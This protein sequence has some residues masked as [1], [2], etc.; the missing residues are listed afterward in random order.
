MKKQKTGHA[1]DDLRAMVTTLVM[2]IVAKRREQ[3]AQ[4]CAL[5]TQI[6]ALRAEV[7]RLKAELEAAQIAVATPLD[8]RAQVAARMSPERTQHA[9][10]K[11]REES[12]RRIAATYAM[13]TVGD[14]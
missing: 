9:Y 1:D 4:M 12:N 10:Q 3:S 7:H 14:S 13:L 2:A 5:N 6:G 8:W 11:L